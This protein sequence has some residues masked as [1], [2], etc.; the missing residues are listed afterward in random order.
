M[1][2]A[3]SLER[4][5][6]WARLE[7]RVAHGL[8]D[9]EQQGSIASGGAGK[10]LTMGTA[11]P[12]TPGTAP[13]TKT[14]V[15]RVEQWLKM[16]ASVAAVVVPFILLLIGYEISAAADKR[17]IEAR[18]VSVSIQVG[19]LLLDNDHPDHQCYAIKVLRLF[20]LT[21]D[22][23]DQILPLTNIPDTISNSPNTKCVVSTA[24]KQAIIN[25]VTPN[26]I[27]QASAADPS[28]S[29]PA[30]TILH[31]KYWVAVYNTKSASD[32]EKFIS[33]NN[34]LAQ[35]LN[36]EYILR[37]FPDS[38]TR[39]IGVGIVPSLDLGQAQDAV[40][41]IREMG[42]KDAYILSTAAPGKCEI[43]P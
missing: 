7:G 34:P 15:D 41:R 25:H 20:D 22:L 28:L 33:D 38:K 36:K 26:Q 9:P 13:P 16:V 17:A 5:R 8:P 12:T 32:A 35:A 42:I 1:Q 30:S 24:A 19:P 14:V 10:G 37:C 43:P 40:R 3:V 6:G 29:T 21:K 11:P 18:T 39:S 27:A 2:R 31:G 23:V 4:K